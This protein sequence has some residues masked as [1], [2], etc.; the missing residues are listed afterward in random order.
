PFQA[1]HLFYTLVTEMEQIHYAREYHGDLH[2]DN[3]IVKHYGL[4]FD[5][6]VIDFY[7]WSASK[8]ENM[9]YDI[10]DMVRI[11]Y[12]LLGGARHYRNLPG[13]IKAICCGLKKG[14]ILKKFPTTARLREHIESMEWES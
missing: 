9:Q 12:D 1:I 11:L 6:K 3:I 4:G 2:T 13:N 10:V 8:R 7:H 14:L 5:L